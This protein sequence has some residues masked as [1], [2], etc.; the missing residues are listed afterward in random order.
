MRFLWILIPVLVG[1]LLFRRE[2]E[3]GFDR[4]AAIP[5]ESLDLEGPDYTRTTVWF[6]SQGTACEAW[7]YLPKVRPAGGLPPLVVMAHGLGAQ[8]DMALA[9]YARGFA[10]TGIASFVFDYRTF[11]GSDGEP[12]NWISPA[13]HVQ[14][15]AAAV[16]FVWQRLGSVVDTSRVALWGSSFAGGHV[17]VTAATVAKNVSCVVSQI[18]HLDGKMAMKLARA[19]RGTAMMLKVLYA[20]ARDVVRRALGMGR[21]YMSLAATA[22][23]PA[24]I[25]LTETQLKSYYSKHPKVYLGGWKC[26]VPASVLFEIPFYS[27]VDYLPNVTAP[28]LF[29]EAA[30][31]TLCPKEALEK[32]RQLAPGAT[33]KTFGVDHFDIYTKPTIVSVIEET[34]AF[35]NQ[36][37]HKK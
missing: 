22:P 4:V 12:R 18:P 30:V 34:A 36:H 3:V 19:R 23:T 21:V 6:Q 7:L 10:K 1:V 28:V 25:T 27:P 35:L 8:K 31:D 26:K 24:A 11:G 13:R 2:E 32:A 17:I 29:V 16:S 33:V 14:D 20:A 15:W 5:E 9:Q 37:F